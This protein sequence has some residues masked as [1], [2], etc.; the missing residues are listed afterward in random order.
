MNRD[1]TQ[2]PPIPF[3]ACGA[4][5]VR[6]DE[7]LLADGWERRFVTDAARLDEVIELY[8]STGYEVRAEKLSRTDFGDGCGECARTACQSYVLIYTRRP[9]DG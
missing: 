4:E 7:A 8:R 3:P 1:R 2:P 5:S 9:A 6:S